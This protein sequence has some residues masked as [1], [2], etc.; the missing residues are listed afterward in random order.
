MA[1]T[2]RIQVSQLTKKYGD[3]LAVDQISFE[4]SRG[5]ILGY[6]GRNGAGKST[7]VKMLT[8]VLP[9]TGGR[10]LIDGADVALRF[11]ADLSVGEIAE[12]L[13]RTPADVKQRLAR[14]TRML[15]DLGLLPKERPQNGS[16]ERPGAGRT[17]EP[18]EEQE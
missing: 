5:E 18:E 4:V 9:P 8:G 10:I 7:T 17:E 1:P 16:A 3:F 15:I 6:L 14:G 13:D 11:G 2:M 12:L